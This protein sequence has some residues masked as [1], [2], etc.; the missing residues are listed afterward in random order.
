MTWHSKVLCKHV[1]KSPQHFLAELR[2]SRDWCARHLH[3]QSN[4]NGY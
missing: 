4:D 1:I 2:R 3:F